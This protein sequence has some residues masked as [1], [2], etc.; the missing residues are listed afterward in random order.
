MH[1]I[2]QPLKLGEVAAKD[3]S[4]AWHSASIALRDGMEAHTTVL[5]KAAQDLSAERGVKF[6]GLGMSLFAL[7][8]LPSTVCPQLFALN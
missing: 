2:L 5:V 3:R 8:C 6:A 1:S 4:A 7:N